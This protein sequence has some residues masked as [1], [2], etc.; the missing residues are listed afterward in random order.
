MSFDRLANIR[1]LPTHLLQHL[2]RLIVNRIGS[3]PE[4]YMVTRDILDCFLPNTPY[5]FIL[6][7]GKP[8]LYLT[9]VFIDTPNKSCARQCPP[10]AKVH[11]D[12]AREI[13]VH[14]T[15]ANIL[16]G[17]GRFHI[18]HQDVVTIPVIEASAGFLAFYGARLISP[19]DNIQFE[20]EQTLPLCEVAVGSDYV[21][22][23]LTREQLGGGEYI[24][25]HDQPHLW[26]P[27]DLDSQ[28][29]I[30]LGKRVNDVYYFTGFTIPF[31]SAVYLSPNQLHSDAYLVGNYLVVYTVAENYSTVLFQHQQGEK[32]RFISG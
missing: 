7:K 1:K 5:R 2:Q 10:H 3:Q 21:A 11:G 26:I 25:F 31:G 27:N 16:G 17:M 6:D 14:Q 8:K 23:Y 18:Q 29:H 12:W 9:D 28:G 13:E 20:T 22:H 19:G 24:E 4:A 32:L 15:Q 30:L